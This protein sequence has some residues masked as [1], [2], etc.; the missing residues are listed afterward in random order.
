M[1]WVE[2]RGK[3]H[4]GC[5][6][7]GDGKTRVTGWTNL[8]REARTAA[9]EEEAK[10]RAGN[11][12]NPSAGKVTF[13]TYFEEWLPNRVIED[14]T[15]TH[16]RSCYNAALEQQ[17]GDMELRQIS[18]GVVQ[19]WV[20]TMI[21][22]GVSARTIEA[23]FKA[24]QTVLAAQ[25]G[26][27][28]LRDGLIA[29]NPC[30]GITLPPRDKRKVDVYSVEECDTIVAALGEWW[31]PLPLFASATGMRWGE[32]MGLKVSDF[33]DDYRAVIVQRT[34][35][36]V[37]LAATGNGTPFKYKDRPKGQEPRKLGLDTEA[38][39]L[40]RTLVRARQLFPA[41][42]V[43]SMPGK[44]GLPDRTAEWPEGRPIS[45]SYHRQSIWI[46]VHAA[47]GVKE[48]RIHD[49]RGSHISWLL[50]GGADVTAVM[51]RAG[52]QQLST[53]QAYVD[54]MGD[55]DERALDALAETRRRSRALRS[56]T[57]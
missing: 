10:L 33:T 36:Q 50:A 19:R 29:T 12:I 4:R 45:R 8:K 48:R 55:A 1:A 3:R 35:I 28:A 51:H 23:R 2:T 41:D 42:R 31:R 32:L 54:A 15:V 7:D 26:V 39:E 6:R 18:T 16:Y 44:G 37:G 9:Q 56:S 25:K 17:F 30:H 11:W 24:L 46:P 5:Y 40:I 52:H 57:S 20:T 13:S 14:N 53:T 38:S 27:S 34:V 49:L 22:A 21:K 47:T 43:F